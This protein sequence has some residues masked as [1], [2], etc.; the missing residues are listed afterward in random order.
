MSKA[1]ET[2]YQGLTFSRAVAFL[3]N[4]R[5]GNYSAKLSFGDGVRELLPSMV[6]SDVYEPNVFHAA[7]NS[8]RVIFIENARDPK[9]AAKLPQWWKSTLSEAR[10]FVILPLCADGKPVG[11]IYGD[12]D[13]SFPA[14][15]LNQTE[16]TLLNDVR[17]LVVRSVERSRQ[18]AL[19]GIAGR[20]A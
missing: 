12:W 4:R 19:V 11:F 17:S 5:D 3:R 18:A 8:D 2:V 1:L 9:F 10:S 15:A 6:F 20:A 7:L 16:F 13:D 14:I